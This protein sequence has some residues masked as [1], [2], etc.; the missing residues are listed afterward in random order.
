[1]A[2][3]LHILRELK[4]LLLMTL[5][6]VGAA[7]AQNSP[8][9]KGKVLDENGTPIIGA[10][11][12]VNDG[13][14]TRGALSD[15]DGTFSIN[16]KADEELIVS[17]L[18]YSEVSVK[19]GTRSYIEV[20]MEEDIDELEEVVVVGYGEQRR[21]NIAGAVAAIDGEEM[22]SNTS[23]DALN[24]LTGRVS[25][26]SIV[27]YSSEPGTYD[28]EI[29]VRGMGTPLIIIDGV[30]RSQAE[31][32]RMSS[33]EIES[34]SI[35]KDASASIY[36]V[37][38]ANGVVLV[39]TK[40]GGNQKAKVSYS[41]RFGIQMV[42]DYIE[43]VSALQYGELYNE[44][45]INAYIRS[46]TYFKYEDEIWQSLKYDQ[47]YFE[48]CLSGEIETY[49]YLDLMMNN[50]AKQ[51]QHSVSVNGGN[52][53][54]TYFANMSYFAEEGLY[55]SG[56]LSSDKINMRLNLSTTI[57]EGLKL[58]MK[59]GYINTIRNAPSSSLTEIFKSAI[60]YPVN[61]EPYAN[62]NLDYLAMSDEIID[63][64]LATSD[65]E[66]SGYDYDDERFVQSNFELVYTPKSIK[67]LSLKANFSYDYINIDSEVF[68]KEYTLY[69]YVENDDYYSP[70]VYNGPSTFE[71]TQNKQ[72]R[73]TSQFSAAYSN[74][75]GKHAFGGLLLFE[76]K[77]NE[78][79]ISGGSTELLIDELPSLNTGLSSTDQVWSSYALANTLSLVSR[80]NY[81]YD[82][83][84]IIEATA[85][86]DGSSKFSPENRWGLF[87][88][89][90]LAWR[91]SE[92]SFVKNNISWL[93]SG[94]LRVSYGKLGDDSS[95]ISQYDTGYTYPSGDI[96]LGNKTSTVL[97][98]YGFD[99][100]W[101]SALEVNDV[102]NT[103]LTWYTSETVNIGLDLSFFNSKLTAEFDV[104]RRTREGL[105]GYR[106]NSDS[107]YYGVTQTQENLNSDMTQGYDISIGTR[108]EIIKGL[109]YRVTANVSYSRSKWIHYEE[110]AYSN[111]YDTWLN[112]KSG[113]Y[114][115]IVW[116]YETDGIYTTFEEIAEAP[117]MDGASNKTILPGSYKY[118]DQNDD[119]VIDSKDIVPIGSGG[120]NRPLLNYGLNIKL[121]YKGFDFGMLWQGAA[122]NLIR[123]LDPA[124]S[125]PFSYGYSS[126]LDLMYDRWHCVNYDDPY[127]S[128]SWVAGEFP[129]IGYSKTIDGGYA[130]VQYFEA[131]Y[132][133]L[134]SLEFGYTLPERITSKISISKC[135]LYVTG[136]NLLTFS[137]CY[138]FVDPEF[139]S[140]RQYS[141]PVTCNFNVGADVTF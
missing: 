38:A 65:S 127:N 111:S 40:K 64:P 1:M 45:D 49:S 74:K 78:T 28:T 83:K 8:S 129:A 39:T 84:Y 10:T 73:W 105:L 59:F 42:T 62:G 116:G 76:S 138:D 26:V 14:S 88:S 141:Y 80:L 132:I 60:I 101:L 104:F 47:T 133:R 43:H 32:S 134:K 58:N 21:A 69:D 110:S 44:Q 35:L 99:D 4:L 41:G 9:I 7:S 137:A 139:N 79:Q 85:R 96:T 33:N 29:D 123:Y 82:D 51:Q 118:I 103:D 48:Q 27:Q 31:F 12:I 124:L 52:D 109:K 54:T 81:T 25:G 119:N 117:V 17:F 30:E 3:F 90:L 120:L 114:K 53:S 34:V 55:K 125:T 24:A 89:V 22:E 5:L 130:D 63:N 23:P 122:K 98:G 16:A 37:K 11:I 19:V 91:F 66:I 36:G 57:A 92:E 97:G 108:G 68:N 67:Q 18:G 93:S 13:A 135:R 136:Y 71:R 95:A 70:Y 140:G 115:D 15:I 106:I 2:N 102:A 128:S 94:K 112:Q 113:R 6:S 46:K 61:Q 121:S 56:S 100:V 131:S 107:E 72:V 75:V 86:L 126:P 77:S 87:P 20:R 50:T